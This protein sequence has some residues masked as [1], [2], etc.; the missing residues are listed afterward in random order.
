M[1]GM[2]RGGPHPVRRDLESFMRG[3]LPRAETRALVLHLLAGC[4]ACLMET[5][6]LWRP[7]PPPYALEQVPG[8]ETRPIHLAVS[9][10]G[11]LLRF[12]GR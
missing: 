1:E 9:L 2:K 7:E 3:E 6:R 4:P 10:R 5:R 11:R 12:N 8:D